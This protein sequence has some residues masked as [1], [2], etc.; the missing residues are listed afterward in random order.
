MENITLQTTSQFF[1]VLS[2][3]TSHQ[4]NEENLNDTRS[5]YDIALKRSAIGTVTKS[6]LL[7]LELALM[8]AELTVSNSRTNLEIALFNFKTYLGISESTSFKLLP[9]T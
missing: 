2:A 5:M 1:S 9:P 4:K 6:E 8:N 7:Q 3:Q